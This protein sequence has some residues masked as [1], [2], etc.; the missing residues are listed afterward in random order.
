M[1]L[2]DDLIARF[3]IEYDTMLN[4]AQA[5][6]RIIEVEAG[7]PANNHSKRLAMIQRTVAD[8]YQLPIE[9]M[10][11]KVRTREYAECRQV[12]MFLCREL[13]RFS[14]DDIAASFR[15]GMDHNTIT[16]GVHVITDRISTDPKMR[17]MMQEIREKCVQGIADLNMPLL[18]LIHI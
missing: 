5:I 13:T 17:Q 3:R 16:H 4:T 2:L 11:S 18:S 8:H 6:S 12:A 15:P 10:A 7:G 14:L 1:K 9:C